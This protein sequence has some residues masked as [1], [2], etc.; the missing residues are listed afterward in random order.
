M[1]WR[2]TKKE[3][4]LHKNK[5]MFGNFRFYFQISFFD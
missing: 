5:S 1:K 3:T 4:Q 2:E